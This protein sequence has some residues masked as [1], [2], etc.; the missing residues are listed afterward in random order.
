MKSL[1]NTEKIVKQF[2]IKPRSEMRGKVLD[3]ALKLQ[4]NRNKHRTFD[5]HIGRLIMKSN[6]TKFA[7]VI[8]VIAA[9]TTIYQL[10]GSIDGAI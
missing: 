9:L 3:D 4:Q 1:K 6:I 2:D 8:I 7:A 10:T 5:T